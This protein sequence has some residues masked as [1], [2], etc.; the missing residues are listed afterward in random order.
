MCRGI[1][2]L[3]VVDVHLARGVDNPQ[4]VFEAMNSTGKKLSQADLIRNFVLMDLEPSQQTHL[5]EGYWYP[6]E[7]AFKGANDRRFDE[8]VRHFLTLRTGTIPRLEDIY[9]AFK[10][11]TA[12][13]AAAGIGQVVVDLSRSARHFVAMA[14][15]K[16]TNPRLA[17]RFIEIEQL[18][19]TV[20][21]PFLLRLY[22]DFAAGR[23]T[24][25][26]FARILD[27][28]IAYLFRRTICRIPTNSLNTTFATLASQVDPVKYVESVWGRFLVLDSYKRFPDDEEFGKY[29]RE[30]DLYHL[31]RAP[32]FLVKMEN[33]S[34]KEPISIGDFTIEHVL[35]QNE[36]L[37][38]AW[39]NMLGPDWADVQAKYLHTLGNLTLTGYNPELSDR[40]F[41]EKRDMAG[42][43]RDSH[44]SLNKELAELDRWDEQAIVG[45]AARLADRA[46]ALWNRP[47]LKP[48]I[49]AEYRT[50][51]RQGQG[52]DWTLT[53]EILDRLPEGR[54]TGYYYLA[55]AVGTSAQA[56]ANHVSRCPH[57]AHPY[58]VLTWDGH[59]AEGFAWAD[60]S[61]QRS[62]KELLEAEGVSFGTGVAHPDAKLVAEDLLALVEEQV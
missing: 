46:I 56:V 20:T 17:T 6:M 31:K 51:F 36:K 37:S 25:K 26:D 49:L 50:Q 24:D 43:F 7:R 10:D 29:L 9:D 55:E 42:G 48:E 62:P 12:T 58:R 28:V 11:Y 34:H 4:L 44:L 35:P 16:E 19:A 52:F 41:L 47:T 8:F 40:P 23:L 33:D 61:D 27:A 5:Y 3:V 30:E 15:E 13:Q 60:P 14:L 39:Q 2:K 45:R 57:C 22:E 18:K 1:S 53:H 38:Q 54:W 32:Y 21:Y 59:I